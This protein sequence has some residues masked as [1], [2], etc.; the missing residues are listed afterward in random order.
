MN[1]QKRSQDFEHSG[2]GKQ[3]LPLQ[4][5][6][7]ADLA[8]DDGSGSPNPKIPPDLIDPVPLQRPQATFFT[9]PH[10]VHIPRDLQKL[11]FVLFFQKHRIV[12]GNRFKNKSRVSFSYRT[13]LE[14]HSAIGQFYSTQSLSITKVSFFFLSESIIITSLIL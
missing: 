4:L 11:F 7:V 2:Q 14:F 5:S 3:P 13:S 10:F 1:N 8:F 9:S 12:W 6:Q